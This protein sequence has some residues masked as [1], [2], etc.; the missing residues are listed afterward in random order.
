[1]QTNK[2]KIIR[3][4][5]SYLAELIRK[6]KYEFPLKRNI[7]RGFGDGIY[8]E[9]GEPYYIDYGWK[10]YE[11]TLTISKEEFNNLNMG[12]YCSPTKDFP[13]FVAIGGYSTSTSPNT[14]IQLT[15][16]LS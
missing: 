10:S 4:K 8:M 15:L 1:M 14:T 5:S 9:L 11:K 13:Y 6:Y 12:D 7:Y 16:H 3:K 2:Y